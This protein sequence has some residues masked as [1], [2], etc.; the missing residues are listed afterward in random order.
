M[1]MRPP[2]T[3]SPPFPYPTRFRSAKRGSGRGGM[4]E[5]LAELERRRAEARLGGGEARIARQHASGKLTARERIAVLLDDGSFEEFG[6]RSEEHTSELQSRE[7][8]VC[9]L[10]L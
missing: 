10:L 5:I 4:K 2:P 3:R 1:L 9:R 8:R 7:N 6:M